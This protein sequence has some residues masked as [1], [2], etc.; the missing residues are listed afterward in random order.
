MRIATLKIPEHKYHQFLEMVKS[1]GLSSK[2]ITIEKEPAR[3]MK[4][5]GSSIGAI[6]VDILDI[7]QKKNGQSIDFLEESKTIEM[8]MHVSEKSL[9]ED[10]DGEDDAH[11]EK[12]LI[13]K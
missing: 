3:G 2:S 10:W 6:N 12:F 8:C 1:L 11:W 4:V 7:A 13:N 9:H 5:S